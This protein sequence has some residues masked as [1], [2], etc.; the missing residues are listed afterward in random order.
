MADRT[1]PGERL[2]ASGFFVPTLVALVLVV[3]AADL[4]AADGPPPTQPGPA[5][6]VP[7]APTP[8]TAAPQPEPPRLPDSGP[9]SITPQPIPPQPALPP[10]PRFQ[11]D[12]PANT[13]L[14]DLLPT[15][16]AAKRPAG[17]AV[18]DD[19]ARVPEVEFQAPLAKGLQVPE[20][21]KQT[22]HTIAKVNH[23]NAKKADRFMDELRGTR[24]DLDGLPFAMG[25]ACRT[26][27]ERTRQFTAAVNAVRG[28]LLVAR[29]TGIPAPT[30]QSGFVPQ[31]S[32][33]VQAVS[34]ASPAPAGPEGFWER[35]EANC[36]QEDRALAAVDREQR[37]RVTQA[38]IAALTQMMMPEA[39]SQRLGLVK[40]LS[41]VSHADATRTLAR[42]AI[43]SA[44]DEVR[45]AAI[46]ALQ[47]RRERDYTDVLVQGLRYPWPAVAQRAGEAIA[48][49]GRTDLA[50][51]LVDLLDEPDPRAPTAR[52]ANGKKETV[53]RE[54]VRVN[55]HRN[56]LLCHAPGNTPTV[57]PE[58]LTASVPVPGEQLPTPFEGYRQ[59]SPDLLVRIDV[60]Y[61]RQDFSAYQPVADAAPWPEM[62]RFDFLVRTRTLTDDEA[63]VYRERLAVGEPGKLSPY[64]RAALAAL[65]ELTG[66]DAE[67][68]A[69]AWRKLLKS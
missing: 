28:S 42:M 19:L 41:T 56:C 57:S 46:D 21:M 18:G 8:P 48:R 22:A 15:P 12:I 31:N 65:R 11:F 69:A 44:E 7:P 10:P 37:E 33:P 17:P 29:Q 49:L 34:F 24:P 20:A 53:V 14:K 43:F 63:K 3:W 16:P 40:Y 30:P 55:H 62:Q 38:R 39:P 59:T 52:E 50:P 45:R 58:A 2:A 66:K 25:D 4:R 36:A 61:L 6:S 47:V 60:T 35:Y 68:T 9:P 13:P 23:V 27:G 26:T 54:L 1:R 64:H 5:P 67:P 51:Q 32:F